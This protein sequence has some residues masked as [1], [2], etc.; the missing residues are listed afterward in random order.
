M[1]AAGAWLED[2]SAGPPLIPAGARIGLA[3]GAVV[4]IGR[5]P[6]LDVCVARRDRVARHHARI[7]NTAGVITLR[8]LQTTGGTFVDSTRATGDFVLHDGMTVALGDSGLRFRVG[9]VDD[10]VGA[11]FVRGGRMLFAL[12]RPHSRT[13][14]SVAIAG[15]DVVVRAATFVDASLAPFSR[16]LRREILE[17]RDGLI[18]VE[19]RDCDG[20]TL[21]RIVGATRAAG[22]ALDNAVLAAIVARLPGYANELHE[23]V[24]TWDGDVVIRGLPEVRSQMTPR[25]WFVVR[26]QELGLARGLSIPVASWAP[27]AGPALGD[28]RAEDDDADA[29]SRALLAGVVRGLFPDEERRARALREQIAMR[30]ADA[31]ARALTTG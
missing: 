18:L 20:A 26:C 4:E 12:S 6:S 31:W 2:A 13:F 10:V 23:V 25:D 11:S 3:D 27:L 15:G 30:G 22:A 28:T 8:D 19:E 9:A 24:I 5:D 21:A 16:I 1:G 14:A 17:V 7:T 29:S